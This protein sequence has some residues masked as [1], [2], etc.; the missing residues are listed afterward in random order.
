MSTLRQRYSLMDTET[1]NL[2]GTYESEEEALRQVAEAV[3]LYGPDSAEVRSLSLVR[4]YGP[5]ERA[6]IASGQAL[7]EQ[8][9]KAVGPVFK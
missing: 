3:H 6:F 8:A 7:A 5:P 4:D 9:L 1:A 2:V